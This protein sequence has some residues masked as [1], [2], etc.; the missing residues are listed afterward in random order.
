MPNGSISALGIS[1][2][3]SPF[4]I[5]FI[6]FL[7]TLWNWCLKKFSELVNFISIIEL[8]DS[9]IILLDANSTSNLFL[10]AYLM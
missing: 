3:V 4:Q 8:S 7:P 6:E 5:D 1:G 2:K 10:V 9:L